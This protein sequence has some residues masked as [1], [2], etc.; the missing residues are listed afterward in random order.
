MS[1]EDVD[2]WLI[3]MKSEMDSIYQNKVWSLLDLPNEVRP[4]ECKWVFKKKHDKDGN[5]HVF[6]ARLVAKRFK[7]VHGIDYDK[8]YSPMAILK[9][10]RIIL[11][12]ATFHDYEIWQMDVK[13][14]FLNG[15]L[16]EDVYMS[17]YVFCL[18]GRAVSWRSSKQ[19]TVA[20]STTESEY[21]ATSDAVK[22]PCWI[23]KFVTEL[24]V[25]PSIEGPVELLCDNTGDIS[26]A[27]EP[28]AHH[29]S[30]HVP[31]KYH[32]IRDML[33]KGDIKVCKV[34]AKT[35]VADP[36]TKPLPQENHDEHA[37]NIGLRQMS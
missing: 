36:F 8:T 16:K 18:N 22:E 21:I 12:I 32:P 34:A 10:I 1:S 31:R 29:K 2:K 9:S 37:A 4:I 24:G 30:K 27:K 26:Q 23:K 25:V 6:K 20:D 11:A 13:I 35:N 14:A 5:V 3:D 19:S 17:G 28:R 33:N 7:Q 15:N